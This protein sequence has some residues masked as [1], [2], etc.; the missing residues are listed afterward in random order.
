MKSAKK[1]LSVFLVFVMVATMLP[2][3]VFAENVKADKHSV[4]V[5]FTLSEDGYYVNGNDYN[6]T[7]LA[8]V[9]ITVD[10][11]D[12]AD[13][14]LEDYYRYESVSFDEGG[15][16]IGDEVLEQ[17]TVLH[18]Y[19]KALEKYYLNGEKLD[20]GSDALMVSGNATSLYMSQFWGHDENLMYFVD[21]K[22]PL[23]AE[24][25]GATSDYILLEDGM[26]I[27]V[28]MFSNWNFW[29]NGAF[30]TFDK[31]EHNVK[32]GDEVSFKTLKSSTSAV[33][34]GSSTEQEQLPG[35]ATFVWDENWNCVADLTEEVS[36]TGEFSYK[37]DKAGKYYVTGID[38]NSGS[39]DASIAPATAV[40]NVTDYEK[41]NLQ[42]KIYYQNSKDN[43]SVRFLG[44]VDDKD[45]IEATKG[46]FKIS[47]NGNTIASEILTAYK[48][49][50]A[51]GKIISAPEGKC[52]VVSPVIKNIGE[53]SKIHVEVSLDNYDNGISRDIDY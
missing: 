30:A 45:I 15:Y 33:W 24:G 37:F 50:K 25:W 21:H 51:D 29:S 42:G 46:E 34:D 13:Y 53:N 38:S 17:P 19:I 1:M 43:S 52:Y 4:T 26:E 44:L 28:A 14:G 20:V 48:S 5:Y 18:L 7:T 32:T 31:S 3:C 23:M 11:F 47:I 9:P 27:D 22:Y 6:Q 35:L 39:E 41:T 8:R 36:E 12:L 49:V 10:Y 16:Y 40:I 2:V